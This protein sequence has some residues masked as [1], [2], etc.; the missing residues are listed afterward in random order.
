MIIF[1]LLCASG[2]HVFE[3]WFAS[4]D[5]YEHQ[6]TGGFLACPIC[7]DSDIGKAL[8]APNIPAKSNQRAALPAAA[9]DAPSANDVKVALSKL[10]KLQAQALA[11]SS[12]V[13]RDFATQARAMDAGEI[14]KARIYGEASLQ[15]AIA[16]ISDGIEIAP[17]PLPIVPPNQSN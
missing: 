2:G 17:L 5:A 11:Q 14:E 12:W 15:E 6:R 7:G 1:D 10:A 4:S 13:G 16:L 9:G 3:A 8:M